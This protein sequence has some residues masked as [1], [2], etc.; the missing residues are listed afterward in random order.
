MPLTIHRARGGYFTMVHVHVRFILAAALAA[1]AVADGQ[2]VACVTGATGFL[3]QELVAQLLEK[4][5]AVRGT[6]RSATGKNAKRLTDM[7]ALFKGKFLTLVEADLL[8]G[9]AGF[10]PCVAGA[11]VLFHTASPFQSTGI[12]DPQRQLIAPAV[13]GTEAATKAAIASGS[14][15]KIVLTSSIAATMGGFGDKDGC[16]DETD[17]NW[18]SEAKIHDVAMDAYRYSKLA[19]EQAFWRLVAGADGVEGAAVL[20]AFIVGPPRTDRT[21]GESL[22]NMV[23]AL[24]GATPPRGDTPM[25]DVRDVAAAHVAAYETP[26][27]AGTSPPEKYRYLASTPT[28]YRRDDLLSLLADAYPNAAIAP[29]AAPPPSTA[30]R[31]RDKVVFCSKNLGNLAGVSVRAAPDALLDM[32]HVM[33]EL[34]SVAVTPRAKAPPGTRFVKNQARRLRNLFKKEL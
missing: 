2:T 16:F 6:V 24:S 19:A 7:A 14:V 8:G 4:G 5:Y 32:A 20:P 26:G 15:K 28:A 1:T 29:R 9:E 30:E 21:D 31:A 11:D 12:D 23:A 17:W 22:G 27:A 13:E 25:V 10:A 34:G 3:G 18:S 33:L